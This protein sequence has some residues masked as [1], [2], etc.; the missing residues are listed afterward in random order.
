MSHNEYEHCGELTRLAATTTSA[1]SFFSGSVHTTGDT[2]PYEYVAVR[3]TDGGSKGF[4]IRNAPVIFS[5]PVDSGAPR[6]EVN[7]LHPHTSSQRVA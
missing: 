7:N 3:F 5:S 6:T 1:T 2:A 4:E